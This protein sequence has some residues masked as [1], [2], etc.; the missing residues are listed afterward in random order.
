MKSRPYY[1][2]SSKSVYVAYGPFDSQEQAEL[3]GYFFKS[4]EQRDLTAGLFNVNWKAYFSEG[5]QYYDDNEIESVAAYPSEYI[6]ECKH[7]HIKP[8]SKLPIHPSWKA[9]SKEYGMDSILRIRHDD[10]ERAK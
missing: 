4:V 2:T 10:Y 3:L 5:V 8:A 1:V 9:F 6:A 7:F